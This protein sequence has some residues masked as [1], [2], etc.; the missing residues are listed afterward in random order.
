MLYRNWILRQMQRGDVLAKAG[1]L[2][3]KLK[4]KVFLGGETPGQE[5]AKAFQDL[6]GDNVNVARW[7]RHMASYT[8]SQRKGF[9]SEPAVTPKPVAKGTPAA[10]AGKNAAVAEKRAILTEI[11]KQVQQKWED[12]KAFD[13]DPPKEGEEDNGKFLATF[14]YPYMNGSLHLGHAFSM[15]K[16]EFA[17]RYHRLQGKRAVF[18]FAFHCT[19][20]PIQAA[21]NKLKRECK[22]Y[23][24]PIPNFPCG[25][26]KTFQITS[27]KLTLSWVPPTATGT[28]EV[29]GYDLLIKTDKDWSVHMSLKPEATI[30]DG[31]NYI[32]AELTD[33]EPKVKYTFKAVT[34]LADGSTTESKPSEQ[35]TLAQPG[36]DAKGGKKGKPQEKAKIAAKTGG[37]LHQWDIMKG[38]GMSTEEI[39]KFTDANKWLEYFPPQGKADLKKL[40]TCADFRR[41]FITTDVNPFYDSFV[42]WQFNKLKE[43]QFLDFGKRPTVYSELDQQACMDHDRAEGEGVGLTEYVCIKVKVVEPLPEVLKDIGKPVYLLCATLRPETMIGQSNCWILPEGEYGVFHRDDIAVVCT[44]RSARNMTFQRLDKG[45]EI[46]DYFGKLEKI[47]DVKGKELMGATLEAPRAPHKTVHLLPLLTIKMN[48]GTGIVTSVPAD[49]PDDYAALMDLKTPEKRKFHGLEDSWVVP[50]LDPVPLIDVTIEGVPTTKC[51]EYLCNKLGV[52]SQKDSEKLQEA[53]DVAYKMSFYHGVMSA[54]PY[55]GQPVADAKVSAK[56]SMIAANEAFVYHDP[57]GHIVSRSGDECVAALIDQWYI[58]YGKDD[59]KKEVE[60]HIKDTLVTFKDATKEQFVEKV[61]WLKEWACSRSFGLGSKIPWDEQFLIE[62]L[63][64]STIYMAYYTLAKFFHGES[65]L[66]GLEK[67]PYGIKPEDVNDAVFDHIFLNKEITAA[68]SSIDQNV[69]KEMKREFEYWYPMDLRVS[70]KDLIPNHLTMSLYN[71]AAIWKGRPEMWPRAMYANGWVSVDN[72]KMSK[73]K[74]NFFSLERACGEFSADGTR[75]SCAYA[76]DSL[77]DANFEIPT[78]NNAI[79]KLVQLLDFTTQ[80]VSEKD[81]L[82]SSS[83]NLFIDTWFDNEINRLATEANEFFKTMHYKEAL[84]CA[85]FEFLGIKDTYYDILGNPLKAKRDLV[86][87]WINFITVMMSVVTPHTCEQ[88]WSIMGHT[89]TVM[90]AKFPTGVSDPVITD[91]GVYL[92]KVKKTLIDNSIKACKKKPVPNTCNLYLATKYPDWKLKVIS[93]LKDDYKSNDATFSKAV[94][95][96][97]DA[98][99]TTDADFKSKGAQVGKF[100]SVIKSQVTAEGTKAFELT[101]PYDEVSLVKEHQGY[102]LSKIQ[103][104]TTLNLFLS[105]DE[106][107]PD[108]NSADNAAPGRPT[109]AFSAK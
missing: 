108:V 5:D 88:L 54:G 36:K 46:K 59:W 9:P 39:V 35:I 107:V 45:D 42:R 50:Y 93:I 22:K 26:P 75:F 103:P 31:K 30:I 52:K 102:L 87:K 20:M 13:I 28:T 74:G 53:H 23:G 79:K 105:S 106:G 58:K 97:F 96:H 67:S 33:L 80:F 21:A 66:T 62:S 100:A 72:E 70:G 27:E 17:V 18:P 68:D 29:T 81:K 47:K 104:I 89:G 51:A 7:A 57:A 94:M 56:D 6:L 64:D 65:N 82:R 2:E 11:E 49:S 16:A 98:K 109:V 90:D 34:K 48:M 10:S 12:S 24:S 95:K 60:A 76:G 19:G 73:S 77:E 41:A 1:K 25:T 4:G 63:S 91:K 8:S 44:Q 69:L 85:W 32:V 43:G 55:K 61:N 3:S 92:E 15:L 86:E 14:P 99:T 83:E 40:G 38:M 84:R 78:A 71:H 37:A 101:L